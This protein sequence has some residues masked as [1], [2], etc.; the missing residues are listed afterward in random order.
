MLGDQVAPQP[1][2]Q[3]RCFSGQ[4]NPKRLHSEPWLPGRTLPPIT[5]NRDSD[6]EWPRGAERGTP[7]SELRVEALQGLGCP[8]GRGCSHLGDLTFNQ[9]YPCPHLWAVICHFSRRI[10]VPDPSLCHLISLTDGGPHHP[11]S[12]SSGSIA[13]MAE[14][15]MGRRV[16]AMPNSM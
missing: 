2:L 6:R 10:S 7:V 14:E 9:G 13:R 3:G 4:L 12:H 5:L 11:G 1:P 15:A 8:E 16:G